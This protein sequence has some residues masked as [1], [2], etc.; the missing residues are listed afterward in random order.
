MPFSWFVI[1]EVWT[2]FE[3]HLVVAPSLKV[4][5]LSRGIRL[6]IDHDIRVV[7]EIPQWKYSCEGA[8]Y[9]FVN[10]AILKVR[11]TVDRADIRLSNIVP[12]EVYELLLK[13]VVWIIPSKV[14]SIDTHRIQVVD[15][16]IV[17]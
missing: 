7:A 6:V 14:K 17:Q 13:I 3:Y 1:K 9:V 15:V 4:A 8:F 2:A 10:R 12:L 11:K 5:Y 16:C